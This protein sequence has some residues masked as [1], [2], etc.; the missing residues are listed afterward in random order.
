MVAIFKASASANDMVK[1][2]PACPLYCHFFFVLL[3][4]GFHATLRQY[5]TDFQG[6][7]SDVEF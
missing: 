6:L 7:P 3:L 1:V 5:R 2:K 4:R